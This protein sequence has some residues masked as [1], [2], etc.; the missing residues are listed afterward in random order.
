MHMS[1]PDIAEFREVFG[2]V[3]KSIAIP[4]FTKQHM[5]FGLHALD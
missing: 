1:C 4:T 2:G 3:G 5:C